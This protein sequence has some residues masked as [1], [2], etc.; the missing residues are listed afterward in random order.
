MALA[1]R[2]S[3]PALKVVARAA[4]KAATAAGSAGS[5]VWPA[6]AHQVSKAA[7]SAA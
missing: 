3:A 4:R 6:P 2:A 1:W 5:A 7:Q